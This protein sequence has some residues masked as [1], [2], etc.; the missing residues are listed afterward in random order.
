MQGRAVN[1][2]AQD[3]SMPSRSRKSPQPF[4]TFSDLNRPSAHVSGMK[5]PLTFGDI[6]SFAGED[7]NDYITGAVPDSFSNVSTGS[8]KV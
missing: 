5:A 8:S 7:E 4:E 2:R 1:Y 6:D 3:A